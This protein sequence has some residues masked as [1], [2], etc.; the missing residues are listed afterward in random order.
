VISVVHH[1]GFLTGKVDSIA[2]VN[3][4]ANP[5]TNRCSINLEN[6]SLTV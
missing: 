3:S 2:V 4:N 1:L 5:K 6:K